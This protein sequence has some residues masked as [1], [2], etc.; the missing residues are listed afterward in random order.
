MEDY[1]KNHLHAV[2]KAHQ[3]A[4]ALEDTM[5]HTKTRKTAYAEAIQAKWAYHALI[6]NQ[7]HDRVHLQQ[8]HQ[9]WRHLHR[10]AQ[11][12]DHTTTQAVYNRHEELNTALRAHVTQ[13]ACDC[14]KHTRHNNV[15][16]CRIYYSNNLSGSARGT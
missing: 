3:Y 10:A 16:V 1:T 9:R 5:A 2:T 8:L 11:L 6:T 4:I 12:E 13:L 14:S 7:H 15:N